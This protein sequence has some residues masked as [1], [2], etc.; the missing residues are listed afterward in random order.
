[1]G[2]EK[3]RILPA[4]QHLLMRE[5]GID[6]SMGTLWASLTNPTLASCSI[7]LNAELNN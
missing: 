4:V 3:R 6:I 2:R 5:H 7:S 1:M